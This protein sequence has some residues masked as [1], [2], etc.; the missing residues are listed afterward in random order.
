MKD[1]FSSVSSAD[2]ALI[3]SAFS[4]NQLHQHLA[5][6]MR[7]S[8]TQTSA[9]AAANYKTAPTPCVLHAGLPAEVLADMVMANMTHLPR[10]EHAAPS[11]GQP[12]SGS[13]LSGLVQVCYLSSP[14]F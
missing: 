11:A 9:Q 7:Q 6:Q 4:E 10:Q 3:T 5:G 1:M 13:G 2:A 12:A 14:A 8:T